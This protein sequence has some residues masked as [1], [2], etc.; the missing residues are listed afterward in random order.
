MP[1]ELNLSTGQVMHALW[2]TRRGSRSQG[3]PSEA[4]KARLVYLRR[5]GVPFPLDKASPGSGS[6]LIYGFQHL[7][8][9]AVA[10]EL[11]E[12][13]IAPADVAHLLT[14]R[15][16]I[17]TGMYESAYDRAREETNFGRGLFLEITITYEDK[18]ALI[19]GPGL[20]TSS[21]LVEHLFAPRSPVYS[22]FV[23][24]L[25]RLLHLAV[26]RAQEAPD[27]RRGRPTE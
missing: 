18:K 16:S 25:S 19:R 9:L 3:E 8:E 14:S 20:F 1:P 7:A 21:E 10:M 15:R 5:A 13:G 26:Q 27:V 23:I 2:R 6:N 12:H 17:L 22:R 11:V 4:F 24:S